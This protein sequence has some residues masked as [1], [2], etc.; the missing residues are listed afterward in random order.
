MTDARREPITVRLAPD[1]K[2]QLE[3]AA[4]DCGMDPGVAARVILE[5]ALRRMKG[6]ATPG[7]LLKLCD[8]LLP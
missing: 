5:A 8:G 1:L 4:G 3:D 7:R 2:R 6:D